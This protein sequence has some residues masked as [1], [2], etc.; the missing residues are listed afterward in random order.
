MSL[1][2][3]EKNPDYDGKFV[4]A[5]GPK[6][7]YDFHLEITEENQDVECRT[8]QQFKNSC[9]INNIL[10]RYRTTG[11]LEHVQKYEPQFGDISDVNY[12]ESLDIIAQANSMW[13]TLPAERRKKF[14]T[15]ENYLAFMVQ[16]HE[17]YAQAIL[18]YNE[19][20][21]DSSNTDNNNSAGAPE[22]DSHKQQSIPDTG[23][24]ESQNSANN[25]E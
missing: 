2:F 18:E 16:D 5:Y 14:Q 4:T 1:N 20:G 12:K 13:E 6:Q 21:K 22:G 17:D 7:K 3:A 24:S 11:V 19:S 10:K 9:D 8:N 15:V 23:G 25:A